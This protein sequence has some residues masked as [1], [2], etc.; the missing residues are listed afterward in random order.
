MPTMDWKHDHLVESFRAFKARMTLYLEDCNVTS[1]A[2]MATKIK[3]AVGDEGMRRILNSGL[4]EENQKNTEKLWNHERRVD[5]SLNVNFRIHWLEF[6]QMKQKS[7]ENITEY[8]SRLRGKATKC[9][10]DNEELNERLIE[11]VTLSTPHDAFRRDI[12]SKPKGTAITDILE[13]G[14]QYKAI[15]ASNASLQTSKFLYPGA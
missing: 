4:S 2:K 15:I 11:M 3:I 6:A 10:F 14:R 1:N 12:L 7:T 5:T 8:V 13:L 9:D